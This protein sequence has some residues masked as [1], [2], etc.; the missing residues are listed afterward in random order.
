MT[1]SERSLFEDLAWCWRC[2]YGRDITNTTKSVLLHSPPNLSKAPCNDK[3][4]HS[5]ATWQR[6]TMINPKR[7]NILVAR[8][9]QS[10]SAQGD[11]HDS[12]LLPKTKIPFKIWLPSANQKIACLNFPGQ[13]RLRLL[14][15]LAQFAI[16]NVCKRGFS[17]DQG[18]GQINRAPRNTGWILFLHENYNHLGPLWYDHT[19]RPG[20]RPHTLV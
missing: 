2:L 8:A 10:T 18:M 11:W 7:P 6:S 1:F 9:W 19:W 16:Q 17:F 15:S 20:A 12:L 3:V 5:C 4:A 14:R 13:V